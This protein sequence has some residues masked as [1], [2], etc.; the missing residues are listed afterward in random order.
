MECP[1]MRLRRDEAGLYDLDGRHAVDFDRVADHVRSG[2][3]FTAVAHD[4]GTDCTR[5]VLADLLRHQA[6]QQSSGALAQ[7]LGTLRDAVTA[8]LP[9]VLGSGLPSRD[10]RPGAGS[11][12]RRVERRAR[13]APGDRRDRS[14]DWNGTEHDAH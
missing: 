14:D 7:G 3:T 8:L 12:G 10:A 5:L 2:G 1:P 11:P 4:S 9:A 6:R 13:K